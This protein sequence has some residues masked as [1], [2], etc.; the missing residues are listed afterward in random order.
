MAPGSRGSDRQTQHGR[1]GPTH[2]GRTGLVVDARRARD[3]AR[4]PLDRAHGRRS[5]GATGSRA[6]SSR[7]RSTRPIYT[8]GVVRGGGR[9]LHDQMA[10]AVGMTPE[11]VLRPPARACACPA[12]TTRTRASPTWTPTAST[13]RCCTRR[14]RCSSARSTRSP[15][16]TTS[17]SSPTASARTT[18]GSPSTA[19]RTRRGCSA[20]AGV[21]LQDVDRAIAEAQRAV[22]ELGLRGVF[23]R[24]S[25]YVRRRAELPLNHSVYDPFWAACQELGVPVGVPP[26]R[27]RRHAG[28]VPQVRA[29]R[30]QPQNMTVT[31]MAMDEIHGGSGARPGGRQRRRH[32]RDAG[33]PAHGRRVRALPGPALP[34]SSSRAAAGCRRSSSAWTSRS[35]RSRSRSAGCRC[36]RAS[37]SSAS[38]T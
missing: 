26:R 13:P 21:P 28:R 31:N 1:G 34:R 6:R 5:A 19:R 23:I 33:P 18:T 12:A 7:T 38:A 16:C 10:A 15:R 24:P 9:E 8:G 3:G 14:R 32:D 11:G 2:G 20:M 27:A 25:A 35:R 17:S 22:G 30:R 36:C 37:T 4:G 29:R